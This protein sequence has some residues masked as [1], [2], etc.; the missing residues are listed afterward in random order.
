MQLA[1]IVAASENDVIGRDNA[2]P[3]HLP[4]DLGY[5]R[6]ITMGKPIIMGRKTHA[7][8]GRPLPGRSNIVISRDPEFSAPGIRAV[9]SLDR[10]LQLA[11]DTAMNDG[12]EEALVIGGAQIYRLALPLAQRIYLTR[13]HTRIAG[14][15]YLPAI[16]W[17]A[18]TEVRRERQAGTEPDFLDYSFVVYEKS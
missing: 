1:L 2:L 5:F 7:S 8:I 14:D 11:R 17:R 16:D 10:A 9:H 18:W 4:G 13:V 15:A 12:A 3:W 6:R